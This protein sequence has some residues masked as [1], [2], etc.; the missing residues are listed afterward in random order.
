MS[1]R[2]T[3]LLL[4]R[5][6][7]FG[8]CHCTDIVADETNGQSVSLPHSSPAISHLLSLC[9]LFLQPVPIP[10]GPDNLVVILCKGRMTKDSPDT[11]KAT[12]VFNSGQIVA[13]EV[14]LGRQ[15][16]GILPI[17]QMGIL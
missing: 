3:S 12:D 13:L 14:P 4:S 6:L 8:C 15:W 11:L 17:L 1:Q 7:V 2:S 5:L 16:I 9:F 10:G